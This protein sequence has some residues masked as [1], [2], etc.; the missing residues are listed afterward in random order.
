[1]W[2]QFSNV[3]QELLNRK[4]NFPKWA[5]HYKLVRILEQCL[6]EEERK[7]VRVCDSVAQRTSPGWGLRMARACVRDP[8]T[9]R[10]FAAPH[11]GHTIAPLP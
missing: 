5:P 10:L 7:E 11:G 8:P 1:V 6:E 9:V 2:A 4:V 3:R